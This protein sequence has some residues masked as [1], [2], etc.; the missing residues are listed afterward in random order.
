ME[1]T[2]GVCLDINECATGQVTCGDGQICLNTKGSYRCICK[3][4][5]KAEGPKCVDVDECATGIAFCPP[6]NVCRNL[7]GTYICSSPNTCPAGKEKRGSDCVDIDECA[8]GQARCPPTTRCVNAD[9]SYRCVPC[10]AGRK[11]ENNQCVDIDECVNGNICGSGSRCVNTEG[12]YKCVQMSCGPGK[13]LQP[14]TGCVDID[15]CTEGSYPCAADQTCQNV[16][17]SYRCQA[18]AIKCSR[19]Y[20]PQN[21]RCVVDIDECASGIARC[22]R[23]QFCENVEGA[24]RCVTCRTGY[25]FTNGRCVDRDECR[26]GVV[27]AHECTNTPGS[28]ICSC[29]RGFKLEPD[30][31]SCRDI[32][33][34]SLP[35][36][37]CQHECRNRY[38]S[39]QCYCKDGYTLAA[40]KRSCDDIDE[41]RGQQYSSVGLYSPCQYQCLNSPGSYR[42]TCPAGYKLSGGRNCYDIDECTETPNICTRPDTVCRN[43]FGYYRCI[44]FVCP[45]KY[46]KKEGDNGCKLIDTCSEIPDCASIREKGLRFYTFSLRKG[47]ESKKLFDYS[48]WTRGYQETVT[49]QYRFASGNEKGHFEIRRLNQNQV[50]IWTR[51]TMTEEAEYVLQFYGE[52]IVGGKLE[53]RYRSTL[54]VFVSRYP[55]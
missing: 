52:V 11:L 28:F 15:E 43:A 41:C 49:I 9:G 32:D 40:D 12:S 16:F 48:L 54:Y 10:P 13:T 42:C 1:L 36:P 34:C 30:K 6:G 17:G 18:S 35:N 8:T 38:G 51:I 24:Y 39:Y 7:P 55:F 44:P 5:Y 45:P 21:G 46:Y 3:R 20:E 4:G 19:G 53:S 47:E 26:I 29:R 27:C 23:E 25:R 50:E 37:P 22:G 2:N 33:E 31:R 14:G